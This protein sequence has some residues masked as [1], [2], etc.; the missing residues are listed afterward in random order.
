MR[1]RPREIQIRKLAEKEIL[2]REDADRRRS[3]GIVERRDA[4]RID[5][6]RDQTRR[7]RRALDLGDDRDTIRRTDRR[8]Q[9]PAF[10][11][12]AQRT[13]AND[14]V[15]LRAHL[16]G[17]AYRLRREDVAEEVTHRRSPE[18]A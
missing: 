3:G 6:L 4:S 14:L 11:G 10:A 17:E 9:T 1:M 5:A 7:R 15:R 12:A 18:R 2:L 8:E 13:L 16:V